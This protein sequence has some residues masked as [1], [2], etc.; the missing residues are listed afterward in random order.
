MKIFK[1]ILKELIL[2][3][4]ELQAI[5]NALEFS[6]KDVI[7]DINDETQKTGKCPLII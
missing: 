3:R 2:I 5:H 6:S 7:N 4:K 1:D